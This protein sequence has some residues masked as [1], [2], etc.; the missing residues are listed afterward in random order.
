LTKCCYEY[1][2]KIEGKNKGRNVKMLINLEFPKKI[3]N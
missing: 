1:I 3:S 2:F